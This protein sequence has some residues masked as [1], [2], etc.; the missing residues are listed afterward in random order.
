MV[1]GASDDRPDSPDDERLRERLA[2]LHRDEP[3]FDVTAR[4]WERIEA[5]QR[6]AP[7]V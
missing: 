6:P 5:E 3:H 2:A 7:V 1:T 4:V